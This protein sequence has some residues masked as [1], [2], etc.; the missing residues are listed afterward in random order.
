MFKA[1]LSSTYISRVLSSSSVNFIAQAMQPIAEN[2]FSLE[3]LLRIILEFIYHV[4]LLAL[5]EWH[6]RGE[7]APLFSEG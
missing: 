1:T 2:V 7:K 5:S 6:M 3:F 4:L